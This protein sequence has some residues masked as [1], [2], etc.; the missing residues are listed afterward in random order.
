[1]GP[2]NVR[3]TIVRM[4]I[5]MRFDGHCA[6]VERYIGAEVKIAMIWGCSNDEQVGNALKAR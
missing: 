2:A 6:L 4:T 1:M 5:R 3:M